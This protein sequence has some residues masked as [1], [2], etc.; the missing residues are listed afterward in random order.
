[1][2]KVT[3]LMFVLVLIY[4]LTACTNYKELR[5]YEVGDY[6]FYSNGNHVKEYTLEVTKENRMPHNKEIEYYGKKYKTV[7]R[8]TEHGYLYQSSISF[9]T[10]EDDTLYIKFGIKRSIR[11]VSSFIP[12]LMYSV[13]SS[14]V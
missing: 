13:S 7:Y 4:V 11:A 1:M 2:K 10:Y 6:D 3:I 5:V 12:N 8:D 14:Y 9:Y